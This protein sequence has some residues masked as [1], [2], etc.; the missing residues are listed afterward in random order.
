MIVGAVKVY[1]ATDLPI[2]VIE[3]P[4]DLTI[5][6][7][8]VMGGVYTWTAEVAYIDGEV[9]SYTGGLTIVD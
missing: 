8:P 6:G 2:G 9:V 4:W 1:E 3:L 5:N 7:K